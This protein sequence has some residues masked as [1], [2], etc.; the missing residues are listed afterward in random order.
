MIPQ[1][2]SDAGLLAYE[3]VLAF[4]SLRRKR[5]PLFYVV[6]PL[7]FVVLGVA[8]SMQEMPNEGAGCFAGAIFAACGEGAG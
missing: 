3:Q 5:L 2:E 7:I 1:S 8:A 6:F 4:E